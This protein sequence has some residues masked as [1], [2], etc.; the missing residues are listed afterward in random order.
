M[1][2]YSN[3]NPLVKL[4]SYIFR[5]ATMCSDGVFPLVPELLN[6]ISAG[7]DALLIGWLLKNAIGKKVNS[8]DVGG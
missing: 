7:L 2:P 8:P 1:G 4:A 6:V 5:S 3:S